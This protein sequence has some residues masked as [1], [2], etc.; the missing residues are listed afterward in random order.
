[1]LFVLVTWQVAVGG[2]LRVL[3]ERA[4]HRLFRPYDPFPVAETCSLLGGIAATLSVL[5]PAVCWVAWR[6]L[7]DGVRHWWL[8]PLTAVAAMAAV[9]AL[10]MPLKTW[11]GR[12]GP[13]GPR[14][15]YGW[16]PSG[17]AATAAVAYG[18]AALLLA[19]GLRL[20]HALDRFLVAAAAVVVNAAVGAGLIFRGYHW[21]VDVLGSWLLSGPLLCGVG[22]A[23]GAAGR[24]DGG[25]SWAPTNRSRDRP[26]PSP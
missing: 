1:V 15:D 11:I 10:V 4:G 25:A 26:G 16:Y 8:P 5:V 9:P 22:W 17:H 19:A 7:R 21:P 2:P 24:G 18:T 20:R 14:E 3:D 23:C 12:P 6:G 13:L